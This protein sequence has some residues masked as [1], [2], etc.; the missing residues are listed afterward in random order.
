MRDLVFRNLTSPDR[1]KRVIV[2]SETADSQGVHSVVRRHFI[3]LAKELKEDASFKMAPYLY[4]LRER[5]TNDVRERFFCKIKGA[6][7]VAVNQ[8]VFAVFFIHTIYVCLTTKEKIAE[9]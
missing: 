6:T 3:Y 9:L 8:K 2:A 1:R 4:A 5:N 7:K